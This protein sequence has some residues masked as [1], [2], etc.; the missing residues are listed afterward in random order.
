MAR[1]ELIPERQQPIT[2]SGGPVLKYRFTVYC[3]EVQ[4][5]SADVRSVQAL[6][7]SNNKSLNSY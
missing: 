2:D 6:V 7:F 3:M 4:L 5:P 1:L